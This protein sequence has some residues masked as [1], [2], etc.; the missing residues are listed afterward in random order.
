MHAHAA[1]RIINNEKG[2]PC[3]GL[4]GTGGQE[5]DEVCYT[6]SVNLAASKNELIILLLHN[7]KI[8]YWVIHS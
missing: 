6:C 8:C 7:Y 5:F 2:L 3:L 4:Y 1:Q